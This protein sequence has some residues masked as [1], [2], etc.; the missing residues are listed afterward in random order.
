[1]IFFHFMKKLKFIFWTTIFT[2]RRLF[3]ESFTENHATVTYMTISPPYSSGY[4][5]FLNL[6]WTLELTLDKQKKWTLDCIFWI[7][8]LL[9]KTW[10]SNTFLF[11]KD[12]SKWENNYVFTPNHVSM[13]YQI[14]IWV[15][16]KYQYIFWKSDA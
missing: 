10:M 6:G 8:R 9:G 15:R 16:N 4:N 1:M 14:T 7:L 3:L 11:R 5:N 12:M 2:L 13:P